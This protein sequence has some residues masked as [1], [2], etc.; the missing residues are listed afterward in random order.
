MATP[1]KPTYDSIVDALEQAEQRNAELTAHNADLTQRLA[2]YTDGVAA[3][4]ATFD[5]MTGRM[6]LDEGGQTS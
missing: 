2:Y 6:P 3:M 5:K 4:R 1:D